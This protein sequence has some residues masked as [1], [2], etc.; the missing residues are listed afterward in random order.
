MTVYIDNLHAVTIEMMYVY[1]SKR[2]QVGGGCVYRLLEGAG[3]ISFFAGSARCRRQCPN[4][5]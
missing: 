4:Y 3:R 5:F 2:K 1:S